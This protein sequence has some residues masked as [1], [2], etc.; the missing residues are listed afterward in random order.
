MDTTARCPG[1]GAMLRAGAQWCPQCY[2][3]LRPT[4]AE[5]PAVSA[6]SARHRAAD[7][8]EERQP[9]WPCPTC[10]TVNDLAADVCG[11][12][13]SRFLAPLAEDRGIPAVPGLASL[14]RGGRLL[15]TLAA[16]VVLL[17]LVAGVLWLLS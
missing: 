13:G 11:G 1:C 8:G 2:A 6:A 3:D 14:S 4:K 9:G 17:L 12:C 10:G 15:A 16:L 5:P 7:P